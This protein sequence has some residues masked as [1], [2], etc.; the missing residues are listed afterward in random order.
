MRQFATAL[1]DDNIDTLIP[2]TDV[3]YL[4]QQDIHLAQQLIHRFFSNYELNEAN[5]SQVQIL[6]LFLRK[7]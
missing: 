5:K 1:H 2:P 4:L 6:S 7:S 3:H